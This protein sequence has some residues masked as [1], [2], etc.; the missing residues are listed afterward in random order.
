MFRILIIFLL[1]SFSIKA[2]Q[3]D[4]RLKNL[5]D[6][7][8]ITEDEKKIG[9]I[10]LDIWDIWHETNDPKINADFF[11]GIGLMNNGNL[12]MSVI[13]FTKVI[14]NNP[15]FAEAWNKRAT[16][17]YMLGDFDKS[18]IDIITTLKLEPRHFG[19]LDGM[20]LIFLHQKKYEKAIQIYEE[21]IKIFPKRK[22]TFEKKQLLLDYIS[23][24]A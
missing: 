20:V 14:Q 22:S 12:E 2:D 9:H 17:Y 8:L 6:Q 10:T 24:S 21:I 23:K 15:N 16:A 3:Y 7:L 18:M 4:K 1:F 19:A 13:Y 11:K 5:F